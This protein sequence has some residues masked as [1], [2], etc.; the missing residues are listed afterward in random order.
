M[1]MLFSRA[2][3]SLTG[4]AVAALAAATVF[5]APPPPG[6]PAAEPSSL[7]RAPAAIWRLDSETAY[8][9]PSGIILEESTR[10]RG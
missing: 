9:D 8:Q 5:G 10:F 6:D 3:S 2:R 7:T 4:L 1:P